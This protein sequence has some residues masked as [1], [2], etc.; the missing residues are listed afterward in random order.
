MINF[1][2]K[3]NNSNKFSVLVSNEYNNFKLELMKMSCI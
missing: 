1:L 3:F 2:I